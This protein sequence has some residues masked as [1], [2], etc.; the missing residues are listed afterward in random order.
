[1]KNELDEIKR[2]RMKELMKRY[3]GNSEGFVLKVDDTNFDEL[4]L[5][6]SKTKPVVVDFWADWCR[7]CKMLTPILERIAKTFNGR[8]ILAKINVDEARKTA[9]AYGIMSIP[10]VIIFKDGKPVNRFVGALPEPQVKE[11]LNKNLR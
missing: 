3:F 8:F 7:P 4:V 5:E 11:W 1:M 9:M 2:R 6:K 10:T